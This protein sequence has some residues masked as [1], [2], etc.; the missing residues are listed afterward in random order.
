[1]DMACGR[2]RS[3][4]SATAAWMSASR[5]SSGTPAR[6]LITPWSRARR[7]DPT[8]STTPNPVSAVPGSIPSTI[9][10]IHSPRR[11]GRL[12]RDQPW[13]MGPGRCWLGVESRLPGFQVLGRAAD[14]SDMFGKAPPSELIDELERLR[15]RVAELEESRARE[16]R[17]DA[18]TGVLSAHGF[19]SR[20]ADEVNR[21]RRYRRLLSLAVVMIDD[22]AAIET[23]HGFRAGDE[24]VA[25]LV[26]R[27][28]AGTLSHDL[29]GR[30]SVAE[31][32]VLLP[33]SAPAQALED[34]E[35]LLLDLEGVRAGSVSAAG[36]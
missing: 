24:L 12:P 25:R 35:R 23:A 36:I 4:S 19:R 3:S 16:R 7:R 18:L 22:F 27:L 21:A 14:S 6:V 13:S 8:A 33:E 17:F 20:F 5:R 28:V 31:F 2:W 34:L 32:A 9:M 29:I 15:A 1:M 30:T 10:G 11:G 26:E